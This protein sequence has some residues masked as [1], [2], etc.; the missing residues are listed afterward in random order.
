MIMR[1]GINGGG[2]EIF[3]L[4]GNAVQAA[5]PLGQIDAEWQVAGI[6]G[7]DGADTSDMLLR[8]SL[9][10]Q[11]RARIDIDRAKYDVPIWCFFLDNCL[12]FGYQ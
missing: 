4:G 7:F 5:Y 10:G 11:T 12:T 8:N 3:D 2:Y 1:D 6:G 9:T